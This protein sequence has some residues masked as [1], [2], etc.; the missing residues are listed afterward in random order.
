M[1][2]I[3]SFADSFN[4][5]RYTKILDAIMDKNVENV[6]KYANPSQLSSILEN[7][8]IVELIGLLMEASSNPLTARLLARCLIKNGNG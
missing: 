2:S 1:E 6:R 3:T 8:D 5:E 7:D 4:T